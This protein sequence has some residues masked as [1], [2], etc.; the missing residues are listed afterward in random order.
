MFVRPELKTLLS[1]TLTK[2]VFGATSIAAPGSAFRLAA[3]IELPRKVDA[4]CCKY[5]A[6]SPM[7]LNLFCA[8]GVSSADLI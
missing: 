5:A 7:L 3:W 4:C 1:T 8:I 6:E 2:S